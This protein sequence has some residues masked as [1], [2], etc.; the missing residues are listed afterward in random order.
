M[1]L[2]FSQEEETFRAEVREDLDA[3]LSGDFA[4]VLGVGGPGYEH[5]MFEERLA[6]E[7]RLGADGWTGLACQDLVHWAH[8]TSRPSGPSVPDGTW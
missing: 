1:D 5:E 2:Q 7:R 4:E 6:W 3:Q 8:C